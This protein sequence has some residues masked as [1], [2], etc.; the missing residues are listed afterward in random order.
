MKYSQK[1]I[2]NMPAFTPQTSVKDD[3][4]KYY[5]VIDGVKYRNSAVLVPL[6]EK[7]N[8]TE[9]ILTIRSNDLPSHAGQISFPGGRVDKTDENAFSLS[10]MRGERSASQPRLLSPP[11]G[12]Q[13]VPCRS[14]R[15]SAASRRNGSSRASSSR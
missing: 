14:R 8:G 5:S 12:P 10:N 9:I 2:K 6:V 15:R 4:T 13:D 11:R 7:S 3:S 1:L